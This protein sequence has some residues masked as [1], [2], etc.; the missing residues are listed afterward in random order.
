[1]LTRSH[2]R[3]PCSPCSVS[4]AGV[5]RPLA[6]SPASS[7]LGP[8]G[9]A[10]ACVLVPR[11]VASAVRWE[12]HL[13]QR[14]SRGGS[15]SFGVLLPSLFSIGVKFPWHKMGYFKGHSSVASGS[16][17][18]L[19]N[20]HLYPVSEYFYPPKRKSQPADGAS[21]L[22]RPVCA[23]PPILQVG[24][25]RRGPCVRGSSCGGLCGNLVPLGG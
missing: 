14:G 2:S 17:T 5:R 23:R 22:P 20:R 21:R 19:C 1:M 12:T 24:P 7:L 25:R 8:W 15:S 6:P 13:R 9:S 18:T 4:P 3:G 16:F 10:S 11:R